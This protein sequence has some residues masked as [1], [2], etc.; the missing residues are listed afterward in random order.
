MHAKYTMQKPLNSRSIVAKHASLDDAHRQLDKLLFISSTQE[1][2]D[3]DAR[4][5]KS[6]IPDA[7]HYTV[8]RHISQ[9]QAIQVILNSFQSKFPHHKDLLDE[10]NASESLT[11]L[12]KILLSCY[13]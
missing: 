5:I 1:W 8:D 11:I 9:Y 10:L 2:I 12:E 13:T 7:S 4:T 6:S 3:F